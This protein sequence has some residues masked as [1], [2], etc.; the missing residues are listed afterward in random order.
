MERQQWE[1]PS[2]S[3]I[4]H[5]VQCVNSSKGW[6]VASNLVMVLISGHYILLARGKAVM[7]GGVPFPLRQG[8]SSTRAVLQA[9]ISAPGP[10][11]SLRC[12][13]FIEV[14]SMWRRN[15]ERFCIPL[16]V[17]T[18]TP[19]WGKGK[20]RRCYSSHEKSLHTALE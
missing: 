10:G 11:D 2:L 18:A 12:M 1:F 20:N 3:Q 4:D 5:F 13:H 14:P 9:E 15:R 16:P 8:S 7:L 17:L 6:R 19:V